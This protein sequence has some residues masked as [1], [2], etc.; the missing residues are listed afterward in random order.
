MRDYKKGFDAN[1]RRRDEIAVSIMKKFS[2]TKVKREELLEAGKELLKD[3]GLFDITEYG[4]SV[5]AEMEALLSCARVGVSSREGV[6]YSTTFPCHN[7]A[8]HI[9]AAGISRVVFVEPYPKS[10]AKNLHDDAINIAN[11]S[12][13]PKEP[14]GKKV[15]FE[16]FVGVGPRRFMDLFSTT[17]S[18]GNKIKR[19]KEAG[20]KITWT[21]ATACIRVPLIPMTYIERETYLSAEVG[22]LIDRLKGER[23]GREKKRGVRGIPKASPTSKRKD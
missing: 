23:D 9:V 8:K 16:P 5:H 17:L 3:T 22:T 13:D 18:S 4:R 19:K 11:E 12:D 2:D 10:M 20:E 1:E 14:I 7:C 6:L 21:P 15:N